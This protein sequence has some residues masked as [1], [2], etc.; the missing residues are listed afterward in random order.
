M[1][2][3]WFLCLGPGVA[4]EEPGGAQEGPRRAQRGTG[5]AQ[6]RPGGPRRRRGPAFVKNELFSSSCMH[7]DICL[8]MKINSFHSRFV[9]NIRICTK[10]VPKVDTPVEHVFLLI[11][12]VV[13][14]IEKKMVTHHSSLATI[15]YLQF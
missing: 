14:L 15:E 9:K 2:V 1:Y 11:D 8:V 7:D 4:Q 10:R 5:E 13:Y 6:E 12:F 3:F